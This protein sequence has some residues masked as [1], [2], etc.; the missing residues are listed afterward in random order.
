MK[1]AILAANADGVWRASAEFLTDDA[2][3]QTR[4]LRVCEADVDTGKAFASN[5]L[6]THSRRPHCTTDERVVASNVRCREW[7][8][9]CLTAHLMMD[10][11]RDDASG[12]T[13]NV[14]WRHCNALPVRHVLTMHS[15][16]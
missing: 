10:R 6:C 13:A 5:A 9:L 3:K 12:E 15:P 1:A 8:M 7:R 16:R 14:S 4:C 11:G 2:W